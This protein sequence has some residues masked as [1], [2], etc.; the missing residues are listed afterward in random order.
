MDK[1]TKALALNNEIKVSIAKT[2]TIAN[3][4]LK[5]HDLWPTSLS[6]LAKTLTIGAI[7]GKMLKGEDALTIKINGNGP[8]GNIIVD[9]NA[10]GEVRGYVDNPHINFINNQNILDDKTAIGLDGFIEV[11]KTQNLKTD[12]S[13]FVEIKTG[14]LANDFNYYFFT[15]EQT[16]TIILLN[17]DISKKALVTESN[18]LLIQ[19]LPKTNEATIK[20]LEKTFENFK[21]T[22]SLLSKDAIDILKSLFKDDY[23][24]LEESNLI[25]NCNCSKLNFSKGLGSLNK[26]DLKQI[27]DEDGKAE[28]ICNYCKKE[29]L[30]SKDELNIILDKGSLS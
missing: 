23:V 20:Y 4:A 15:S 12:F 24:I 9:A 14:N 10:L 7:M 17:L 3:T 6:V 21:D 5:L 27:I 29:Y 26:K 8:I 28:I 30:F 2:K 16:P 11:I 1:I 13:S 22:S 19:T 25:Y 18:G